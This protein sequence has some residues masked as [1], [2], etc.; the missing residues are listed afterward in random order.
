MSTEHSSTSTEHSRAEDSAP[1]P[2]SSTGSQPANLSLKVLKEIDQVSIRFAGDSGDGMQLAGTQFTQTSALFGN[3]VATFP[4][5]PAE[6]RAPAGS[7]PGVSGF[8][9]NFASRDIR[10][11]GDQPDV[12]VAM[13]PAALKTNVKDLPEGAVI[14]ANEDAFSATN[15]KKAGYETNPLDD[16]SLKRFRL[17]K[18]PITS[19][20]RQ[21]LEESRL[22][23]KQKDRCKN[24]YALGLLFWMYG[25]P[26]EPTLDWIYKKFSKLPDV[27]DANVTSLKSGYYFGK[28]TESLPEHYIVKRANLS[29]GTYR[30]LTG[31]EALALGMVA[32][33]KI[34]DRPLFYGSY[35]ITPASDILH[36][37]AKHKNFG[38][39]T[40][41]AEDEIAA[42]GSAIGASFGGALA[43]T[44]SSGPGIAL[45]GE[46]MGLAV[47]T[48]LPIVVINVQ[49]AGPSTG[50]PTKVEQA[51]LFQALYGRNGEAPVAVLA[52]STPGECFWLAIEAFRLATKYMVP[53]L[54]LSDAYLAN[55]AEP[56]RIPDLSEL[57]R[58]TVQYA[59]GQENGLE[60][61]P[62]LRDEE[63]LARPWAVPGTRGLAHRIGGL[64]KAENTGNV[65]YDPANHQRMTDLRAE[66]IERMAKDIPPASITGPDEGEL[67][68]VGWGGTHG[69]L[70]S[71]AEVAREAGRKVAHM[72]LSYLNPL[73]QNVGDALKRYEKVLVAEL[74]MGQLQQVLRGKYLVD[75]MGL[76]KVQGRPFRIS[77]VSA[78]IEEILG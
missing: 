54:Y 21:A 47:M 13:N 25:R 51:D 27:A 35:P 45:K 28:T 3:D 71:A 56:F 17:H 55:G 18:I 33:S 50:M 10:T 46:A 29:A 2:H 14:I 16:G 63:T 40:F 69:A 44:G 67:L 43:A 32:A 70:A 66:K 7:L 39:R 53:V 22:N 49:R 59:P 74:N 15:L 57:P 68:I 52:P 34:C 77:E 37:L 11:P 5:Y 58:F 8:Q 24:F 76:H 26:L 72:H 78:K 73:P 38:V 1:Q 20:N 60:F 65:S 36:E 6:I 31:N 19:Q 61:L 75:A 30:N 62:Y 48:E 4:D 9:V 41:Q 64:E 23:L 12:L 42:V